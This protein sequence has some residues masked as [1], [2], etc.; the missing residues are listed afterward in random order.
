MKQIFKISGMTCAGCSAR[1]EKIV[2]AYEGVADCSVNLVAERLSVEFD[3]S[4]TN[5]DSICQGVGR[6]GFGWKEIRD[7]TVESARL[8]KNRE[9]KNMWFRFL[10][11]AFFTLPLFYIAMS[12]MLPFGINIPLPKALHP[13]HH[14][15]NFAYIQ[16]A[17]M[18]PVLVAGLV[19]YVS[20]F[21][22]IWHRAPNMDSLIALGTTAAVLYSLYSTFQI[23]R[24]HPE[25]AEHLYYETAAMIVTLVLLGKALE[26]MSLA[27]VG[28]SI[29]KMMELSPK[30]AFVVRN[31]TEVELP[32]DSVV[33]GDIVIIKPGSKI[34]VDGIVTE[35]ATTMDESPLTGE[36][37]PIEKGIGDDVFAATINMSGSI[38]FKATKVGADTTLAQ[39]IKLV[40]EAQG[41]KAPIAKMADRVAGFFVP[42]V[43]CIATIS[44]SGW[45][46]GTGDF[47]FALTIFISVLVIACPC[48]LGLATPT[49]IIVATGKGAENGILIRNGTA[50]ETAHKIQTVILDK[51]GTITEGRPEVTDI[52]ALKGIDRGKL[53]QFV[54]SAEKGSEHPLG[55]AIVAQAKKEKIDLLPVTEF[56][57]IVG[58][59][60][61]CW[62]DGSRVIVGNIKLMEE[63]DISILG[64]ET[65]AD[66][67]ASCGKTPMYVA[68]DNTIAGIIAVAD[69]LKK[70]SADAIQRIFDM[71]MDV[72]MITG[73]NR[74]TARAIAK[75]V[76][77]AKVLSEVMPQ[78]KSNEIQRLQTEGKIVAMVGDGIND[79]PALAQADIGIAIGSGTDVAVESSDM[80]LMHCDLAGVHAAIGLSKATIKTIRQNLFWAFG[81]NALGIPVAAGAL[82]IFGGPLLSPVLAAVAMSLSCVS[83][84]A[85]TLRLRGFKVS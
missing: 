20:G 45:M 70:N 50:I 59:G 51:T 67:I 11:S 19:F 42:V 81:Y 76:G 58:M 36:S 9:R 84:L 75:K 71:G 41:S 15:L 49:A 17:F 33:V 14:P 57:A 61:R 80:V 65:E 38:V 47:V 31:G 27:K 79:A 83:M 8:A 10:F 2:R 21:R 34:P 77:I 66:H 16:I 72:V 7:E 40:T 35:G 26:A 63:D 29:K 23:T 73:D 62:V 74:N 56:E 55:S 85:N 82:H 13:M 60:V 4:K 39:I 69:V 44:F 5:I 1:L 54:A 25:F 78:A 53:L 12:H 28:E 64:L 3:P 18:V 52:V 43:F 46:I 48:A 22:G 32:V 68:I 24:G 30:T 6:A 37:M